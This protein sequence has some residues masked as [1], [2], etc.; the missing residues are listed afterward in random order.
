MSPSFV[1]FTVICQVQAHAIPVP[2][3]WRR[4]LITSILNGLTLVSVTQMNARIDFRPVNRA[5][6]RGAYIPVNP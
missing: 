3:P 6:N 2:W 5:E 4:L 1:G